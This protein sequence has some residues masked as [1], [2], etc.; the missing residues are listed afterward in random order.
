MIEHWKKYEATKSYNMRFRGKGDYYEATKTW[1][2]FYEGNQWPGLDLGN[3]L[4]KPV[5]NIIKRIVDFKV[6]NMTSDKISIS[7]QPLDKMEVVQ[8]GNEQQD[9]IT[10]SDVLRAEIDNILEKNHIDY[11]I[12]DT[13]IDGAVTGDMV[14]HIMYNNNATAYKKDN[15]Q[16]IIEIEPVDAVNVGFSNPNIKN[17]QKQDWVI[18]IGRDT[19][20][21]LKA[22]KKSKN[23]DSEI[24]SDVDTQYQASSYTELEE[25]K[26]DG[27]DGKC[28][29]MYVYEKDKKTKTIKVSKVTENATIFENID[30]GLKY[31]P[32]A[33]ENWYERK[34]SYH[35]I[36]EVEGLCPNQIFINK[37]LAMCEYHGLQ[38]AFPLTL[39]NTKKIKAGTFNNR[40]GGVLE[41]PVE[42][43]KGE[44]LRDMVHNLEPVNMSQQLV[45]TIQLSM[46]YTKEVM[47]VTDA[48]LGNVDPKNTS[49]IIAV[50]KSAEL[51]IENIRNNMYS[52]VEQTALI[53]IDMMSKKYGIRPVY[54]KTENGY[55]IVPYDFSKLEE[56]DMKLDIDI[57]AGSYYS[58]VSAITTLDNL[59]LNKQITLK[60]YLERIPDEYVLK[61]QEL[62]DDITEQEEIQQVQT[63]NMEY[64]AMA[65]LLETL[66]LE[67]QQQIMQLPD[68]QKE[69]YLREMLQKTGG[70]QT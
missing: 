9:L 56:I 58:E 21:H 46:D 68:E 2:N 15:I 42:T 26:A 65:Q 40:I 37:G 4:P 55:N 61:R 20:E 8:E 69:L 18:L 48:S 64:E 41:V 31:F 10:M 19:V 28:L 34:N 60:Q 39:I 1:Y 29:Y 54:M 52:F 25:I 57:G 30:T 51:P 6:A 5:F 3:D 59:L 12:R 43:E 49:A 7:V 13:L 24:R 50:Q 23:A 44:T 32:I 66:P 22:E 27:D 67:L 70:L 11:L 45:Q 35:G 17:V 38:T 33:F 36:G 16:G 47:G 63:Q 62:L 14:W 53:L